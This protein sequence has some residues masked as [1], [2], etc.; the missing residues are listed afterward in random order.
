MFQ[1]KILKYGKSEG[2][3][4]LDPSVADTLKSCHNLLDAMVQDNLVEIPQR[5][6]VIEVCKC[7]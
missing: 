4:N 2:Y 5:N 6:D 1:E 7:N 3:D